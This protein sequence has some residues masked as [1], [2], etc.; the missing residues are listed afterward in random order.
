MSTYDSNRDFGIILSND[1]SSETEDRRSR[2]REDRRS[3]EDQRSKPRR[4]RE[5]PGTKNRNDRDSQPPDKMNLRYLKSQNFESLDIL[6]SQ[7]KTTNYTY[8]LNTTYDPINDDYYVLVQFTE[9]LRIRINGFEYSFSSEKTQIICLVYPRKQ[10][11]KDKLLNFEVFSFDYVNQQK[12]GWSDMTISKYNL[13]ISLA[14]FGNITYNNRQEQHTVNSFKIFKFDLMTLDFIHDH[15]LVGF[16]KINVNAVG[17]GFYISGTGT[18]PMTFDGSPLPTTSIREDYIVALINEKATMEWVR[19]GLASVGTNLGDSLV[20]NSSES[21][22]VGENGDLYTTGCFLRKIKLDVTYTGNDTNLQMW[23]AQIDSCG[24]WVRSGVITGGNLVTDFIVGESIIVNGGK[25]IVTG[26]FMG[27]YAVGDKELK[28]T[29]TSASVFVASVVSMKSGMRKGYGEKGYGEK[30][31][32]GHHGT[33]H[34]HEKCDLMDVEQ[35]DPHISIDD[36]I[37]SLYPRLAL[38]GRSAV[39]YFYYDTM[40]RYRG[41]IYA[42]KGSTDLAII[43][44]GSKTRNIMNVEGHTVNHGTDVLTGMGEIVIGGSSLI[45]NSRTNSFII[46]YRI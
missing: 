35:I 1:H 32:K 45:S 17:K 38:V 6:Q 46:T 43:V 44:L 12:L 28:S 37:V 4:S 15:T 19:L 20:T 33:S 23:W 3:R 39:L 14:V 25:V 41:V 8:I 42:S 9:S 31:R 13:V 27:C 10:R 7:S 24:K 29:L 26:S 40:F 21:S 34:G 5:R 22:F 2:S 30:S 11:R 36:T 18:S 16:R